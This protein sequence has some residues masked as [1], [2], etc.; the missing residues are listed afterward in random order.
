[1]NQLYV[2][3]STDPHS[4][5]WFSDEEC[6]PVSLLE[7]LDNNTLLTALKRAY[8]GMLHSRDAMPLALVRDVLNATPITDSKNS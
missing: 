6:L 4:C 1:M 7:V 8:I 3:N 2:H 5:S